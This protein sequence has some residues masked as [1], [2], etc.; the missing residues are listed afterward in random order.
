MSAII[1]RITTIWAEEPVVITGVVTAILALL[2]SVG[3][4]IPEPFS[5]ALVAL[6][7]AI[8]ILIARAKSTSPATVAR[9]LEGMGRSE[10]VLHPLTK[11]K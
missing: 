11:G 5:V 6:I 2:V 10:L 7:T 8:G 4:Q 1:D 3:V 9:L